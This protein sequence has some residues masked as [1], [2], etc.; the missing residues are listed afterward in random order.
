MIRKITKILKLETDFSDNNFFQ[1]MVEPYRCFTLC[2]LSSDSKPVDH[3][4]HI[5]SKMID[6]KPS[7]INTFH[8]KIFLN[9][10]VDIY[11]L[12]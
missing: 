5:I 3:I 7:G 12:F 9:Y 11:F 2:N 1:S 6:R 8:Q 4:A 10:S